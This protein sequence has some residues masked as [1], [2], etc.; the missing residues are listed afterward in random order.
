MDRPSVKLKKEDFREALGSISAFIGRGIAGRK[1]HNRKHD[2]SGQNN[3]RPVTVTTRTVSADGDSTTESPVAEIVTR[4][5]GAWRIGKNSIKPANARQI[6]FLEGN[7]FLPTAARVLQSMW[8]QHTRK[9]TSSFRTARRN[10]TL[11]NS[12]G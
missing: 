11:A 1:Y 7:S 8:R 9:P 6:T 5:R 4:T 12:R 3:R 2:V 10:P